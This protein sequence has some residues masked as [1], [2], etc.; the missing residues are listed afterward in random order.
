MELEHYNLTP[1]ISQFDLS[2]SGVNNTTVGIHTGAGDFVLKHFDVPHGIDGLSYEHDLLT[3]LATQSLSFAVPAPTATITGDTYYHDAEGHHALMPLLEG[4]RPDHK[5]PVQI[6]AVG[7]A[8]GELHTA[9][10]QYP[11]TPRP[12]MATFA[13][14]S[15]IHPRI[16]H[17]ESLTSTDLGWPQTESATK[18]CAWW[19]NEFETLSIFLIETYPTLPT[20]VIHG[21]FSAAFL[22]ISIGVVFVFILP[23]FLRERPGERLLPWTV[24]SPSEHALL[25]QVTNWRDILRSLFKAVWLPMS[26]LTVLGFFCYAIGEGIIDAVLDYGQIFFAIAFIKIIALIFFYMVNLNI[27]KE[28]LVELE[29]K[30]A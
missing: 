21:D 19:R 27:H 1:P 6:E 23:L 28:H 25:S 4:H 20:Q 12:Y 3:W 10:S 13:D 30:Q 26:R 5:N 15:N 17:P 14:L 8:L 11:T 9:L 16:P 7:A 2:N 18:L 29:A 22:V 24:G